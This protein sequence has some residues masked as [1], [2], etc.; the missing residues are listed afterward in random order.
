[1][2]QEES[3]R[4]RGEKSK[5]TKVIDPNDSIYFILF[6]IEYDF[7]SHFSHIAST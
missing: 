7:L 5:G 2:K 4:N 6:Q 1:M 3:K